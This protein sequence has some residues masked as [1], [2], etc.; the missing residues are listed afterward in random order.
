MIALTTA[1]AT[2]AL[3]AAQGH[4]PPAAHLLLLVGAAVVG[5]VILGINRW[6]ARRDAA[7]AEREQAEH[8]L[9]GKSDRPGDER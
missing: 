4:Q 5:L 9:P 8:D 2:T 3:L 1:F 7:A 6:R